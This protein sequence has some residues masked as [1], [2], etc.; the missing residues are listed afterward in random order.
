MLEKAYWILLISLIT[1]GLV[2]LTVKAEDTFDQVTVKIPYSVTLIKKMLEPGSYQ[3]RYVGNN[4]IRFSKLGNS[5][6]VDAE[7][8]QFAFKFGEKAKETKLVLQHYGR[9][10]LPDEVWIQGKAYYYK[11]GMGDPSKFKPL[12]P[13]DQRTPQTRVAIAGKYEEVPTAE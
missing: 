12:V 5:T 4:K 13:E 11:F 1:L 6:K 7:A 3:I 9:T 2:T 8:A 10:Y